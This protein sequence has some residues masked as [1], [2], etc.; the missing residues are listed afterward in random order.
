M[1]YP[2]PQMDTSRPHPARVH[3]FLL[4]GRDNYPA[5]RRAAAQLPAEAARYARQHRAFLLR[6]V[7]WL[8]SVGVDQYLDVGSGIPTEPNL[9]QIVQR[10]NPACRT[11]YADNDPLALRY[12]QARLISSP[13]G[14]TDYIPADVRDPARLLEAAG[15]LL[16]LG[17]P[18]A[19]SLIALMHLLPDDED[20]YGITATL[21]GAL[22]SG[23]HVVLSHG[24]LDFAPPPSACPSAHSSAPGG[25]A[26]GRGPAPRWRTRA[27]VARFFTGLDLVEP[28]LVAATDWYKDTPRP[29][30]GAPGLYVGVAR[31]P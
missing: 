22:P 7:G 28:G 25:A 20:P 19:L 15:A 31:V 14:S 11:V 18:V 9:H 6:A 29:D 1:A 13:Q 30:D 12:A 10:V 24:T 17:R 23:S 5:D 2:K 4:G 3:D 26:H 21:V 16:D 8:A 27:E